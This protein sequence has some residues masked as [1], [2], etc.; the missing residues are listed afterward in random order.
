METTFP[1]SATSRGF[2]RRGTT[3]FGQGRHISRRSSH[4]FRDSWGLGAATAASV[5]FD[6]QVHPGLRPGAFGEGYF[7]FGLLGVI[8][9][10]LV[11]GITL[12]WVDTEVKRAL[13]APRPSM[14]KAFA[15]TMV[16]GISGSFAVSAGFS[17][18]YV[19]AAVYLISWFC[20]SV[21]RIFVPRTSLAGGP[22]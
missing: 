20:L 14:M 7:N 4:L 1:I 2:I 17:G 5:G 9:V 15:A 3:H 12:R 19:L 10:G 8:A 11:L 13:S 18:V 16:L 22:E 21:Q 6:P